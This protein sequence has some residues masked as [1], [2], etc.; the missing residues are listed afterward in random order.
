[1]SVVISD[2]TVHIYSSL[3]SICD[4]FLGCLLRCRYHIQHVCAAK[5]APEE[6]RV[7]TDG[8]E[9]D[10]Y[11]LYVTDSA[12]QSA[13]PPVKDY[14]IWVW[15]NTHR[16][17]VRSQAEFSFG[18]AQTAELFCASREHFSHSAKDDP[19]LPKQVPPLMWPATA[20]SRFVWASSLKRAQARNLASRKYKITSRKLL[21]KLMVTFWQTESRNRSY[22]YAVW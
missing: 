9:G 15:R 7:V 4:Y 18:L 11:I 21:K 13:S 19:P 2:H 3:V 8:Y 14:Y 5:K 16:S 20:I 22:I 6:V 17:S 12:T 10:L 1:M